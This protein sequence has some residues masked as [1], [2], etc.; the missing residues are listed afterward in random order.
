ME[1]KDAGDSEMQD[2]LG[3][4]ANIAGGNVKSLLPAGCLLS[5]PTV[6]QGHDHKFAVPN[7][8]PMS[9]VAFLSEG[10][11]LLVKVLQRVE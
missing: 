10:Q 4:L 7:S 1:A 5:L 9:E 2:A 11:T 6:A 3:E 8:K